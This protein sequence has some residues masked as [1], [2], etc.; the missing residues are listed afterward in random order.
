MSKNP[1]YYVLLAKS[2]S[3]SVQ[4]SQTHFRDSLTRVTHAQNLSRNTQDALRRVVD[5]PVLNGR[6]LEK[7]HDAHAQTVKCAELGAG[8]RRCLTGRTGDTNN[9]RPSRIG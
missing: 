6:D 2:D 5:H 4:P 1:T 8:L 7:Y 3:H 9:T